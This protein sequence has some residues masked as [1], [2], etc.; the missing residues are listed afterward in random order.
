[1]ILIDFNLVS[2]CGGFEPPFGFP[3]TQFSRILVNTPIHQLTGHPISWLSCAS[4]GIWWLKS[5]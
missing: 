3:F 5:R 1:L 2:G 4:L